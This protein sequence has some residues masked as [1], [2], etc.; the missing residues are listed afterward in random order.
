MT[1]GSHAAHARTGRTPVPHASAVRSRLTFAGAVRG[2][3]CKMLSLKST[4]VLSLLTALLLP[5]GAA[6]M[7]WAISFVS[8]ID[9]ETGRTVADP[10]PVS[11]GFMWSCVSAF[12]PTCMIV[13]GIFGVMAVATEY[14]TSSIQASLV[15]DPRRVMFMN[16]KALVAAAITFV[17]S[18]A[19]LLLAW[20]ASAALFSA[21]GL[22]P[23]DDSQRA[24]PWVSVLGGALLLTLMTVMALGFGGICRS[25]MG[26]VFSV[27]GLLMIVPSALSM[28][29]LAGDGFAW[30]QSVAQCLPDRAAATFLTAGVDTAVS[31]SAASVSV[32]AEAAGTG[33]SASASVEAAASTVFEPTWWQGGLIVLAWTALI[34]AIGVLV[35]R[36][37]DVK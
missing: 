23:L 27:V 5:A 2:E 7:A 26:G 1:R 10:Q 28:A 9:P 31:S 19:G 12:V 25:T 15:V 3:L 29:S 8:T 20:W 37:S 30:V 17:S 4:A 32:S 35:V 22:T 33:A 34:Y 24:L 6:I 13:T 16:A 21:G 18:L 14:T 11:A 36:R